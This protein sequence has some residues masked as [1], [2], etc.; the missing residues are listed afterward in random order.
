ML[1]V[2]RLGAAYAWI[3]LAALLIGAILPVDDGPLGM[4]AILAP[5][6]ALAALPLVPVAVLS[7]D[8]ALG[9]ALA[10]LAAVFVLRLGGEWLS[11]P[12]APAAH[13]E[14]SIDVITWNVEAGA[15][16]PPSIVAMLNEHPADVLVLEELTFRVA[17][18]IEADPGIAA[19]YPHQALFPTRTVTG[20][21][22]L[23][24]FP[25]SSAISALDPARFEATLDVDGRPV[26]VVGAH[27][28]PA[29]IV[30]LG[31]IPAGLAPSTR[32]ADL[33][34]LRQRVLELDAQGSDV[35]FI[36]DFNTAPT[37]PAFGR[38]TA[39]LHDAHADAG[40]GPGWTW[41]PAPLEFLGTGLLRIDLILSTSRLRATRTSIDCPQRGDHCLFE[42]TLALGP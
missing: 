21:G 36:G 3:A 17:E 16:P 14:R 41:R 19:R 31:G 2:T 1:A 5:Y 38:L 42:A 15:A 37:E 33:A 32:N 6:F 8:R 18:A 27:P 30:R 13:G 34:L 39:G 28:F 22:L 9:L 25:I 11:L 10:S 40:I 23:S 7:R 12:P 4:L 26:V 24:A 35:L 20:I 29:E